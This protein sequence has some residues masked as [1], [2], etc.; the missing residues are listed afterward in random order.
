MSLMAMLADDIREKLEQPISLW[1]VEKVIDNL[2]P[3]K[4]PDP[5]GLGAEFSRGFDDQ[6]AP[7]LH[8]VFCRSLS[9]K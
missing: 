1:E 3:R 9:H 8:C 7:F 6:L 5:D 2:Q 4:S